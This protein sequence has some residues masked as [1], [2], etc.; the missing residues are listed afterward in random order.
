MCP[1]SV[2]SK[3][4][5]KGGFLF[6]CVEHDP[7]LTRGIDEYMVFDKGEFSALAERRPSERAL[8]VD[9]CTKDEFNKSE[10][11]VT[12]PDR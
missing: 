7:A 5:P 11:L 1:N 10:S 3:P 8:P 6:G 9:R 12:C 4:C 2:L